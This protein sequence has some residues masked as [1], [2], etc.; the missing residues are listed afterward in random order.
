VASETANKQTNIKLNQL[1]E[2]TPRANLMHWA[3]TA[4]INAGL[5]VSTP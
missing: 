4:S 2:R 5:A 1:T 3:T